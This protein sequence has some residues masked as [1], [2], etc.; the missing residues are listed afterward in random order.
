MALKKKKTVTISTNKKGPCGLQ[1]SMFKFLERET[2]RKQ[3]QLKKR[4]ASAPPPVQSCQSADVLSEEETPV[5]V[6]KK[7]RMSTDMPPKSAEE[8][9]KEKQRSFNTA[10]M[11]IC[12]A[13][14][15]GTEG[16]S[17]DQLRKMLHLPLE[18]GDE[19]YAF[20]EE[21]PHMVIAN[22]IVTFSHKFC[23]K[24]EAGIIPTV[25]A[26]VFGRNG[27]SV[28]SLVQNSFVTVGTDQKSAETHRAN[29]K[30][31]F[32]SLLKLV[33]WKWAYVT[34]KAQ[35]TTDAEVSAEQE[36]NASARN[37]RFCIH[38]LSESTA[39]ASAF[40]AQCMDALS[41]S[42]WA[43]SELADI[44]NFQ[45]SDPSKKNVC[46]KCKSHGSAKALFDW[47]CKL[48]RENASVSW[49]PAEYNGDPTSIKCTAE[50]V[51]ILMNSPLF[52]LG[53]KPLTQLRNIELMIDT[54]GEKG[55]PLPPSAV[56]LLV[57]LSAR[58]R[59]IA[60]K[61]TLFVLADES[62]D[63]DYTDGSGICNPR[64]PPPRVAFESIRGLFNSYAPMSHEQVV[65]ELKAR[66]IE[67]MK[68][69]P[70]PVIARS[71]AA[72]TSAEG[73]ALADKRRR[74][75]TKQ[76]FSSNLHMLSAEDRKKALELKERNRER[77]R[78]GHAKAKE[79]NATELISTANTDQ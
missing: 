48:E 40:K 73:D 16:K 20:I 32:D 7:C 5:A 28:Q 6:P 31:C 25:R 65:A 38:N 66:G 27:I 46:I 58:K 12:A 52:L 64:A 76:I 3:E 30:G 78:K 56:D 68:V 55:R 72:S 77:A 29:R 36:R 11:R 10:V 24:E 37:K 57:Q 39:A 79:R 8:I 49:L 18:K 42:G 14:K 50:K 33:E 4:K 69:A 63:G 2:E 34:P 60:K 23:I 51:R 70:R 15:S 35:N 45:A 62:E 19:H 22:D 59:E 67:P 44:S 1:Q 21:N 26:A 13:V 47:A 41:K 75:T 54:M 43:R 74:K 17:L 9:E 71:N 53:G 61:L